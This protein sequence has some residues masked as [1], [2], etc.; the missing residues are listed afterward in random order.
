MLM[1][2]NVGT[3]VD[4]YDFGDN[5]NF[6][7]IQIDTWQSPREEACAEPIGYFTWFGGP[8]FLTT[9]YNTDWNEGPVPFPDA[10][11]ATDSYNQL[12]WYENNVWAAYSGNP[13]VGSRYGQNTVAA[14][15]RANGEVECSMLYN[16]PSASPELVQNDL[17]EPL[18]VVVNAAQAVIC[19]YPDST[20]LVT[21]TIPAEAFNFSKAS[22]E[23]T[24]NSSQPLWYAGTKSGS[25]SLTLENIGDVAQIA[26]IVP[27][28]CCLDS[29]VSTCDNSI[30][31]FE[32][33]SAAQQEVIL[34][35]GDI[36]EVD[37]YIQ[38]SLFGDGYCNVSIY[39]ASN[40]SLGSIANPSFN[41]TTGATPAQVLVEQMYF[42]APVGPPISFTV[43][44]DLFWP[45]VDRLT[46]MYATSAIPEDPAGYLSFANG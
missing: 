37:L 30:V 46:Y 19:E 44:F 13:L 45:M 27:E 22:L 26:T 38:T 4:P 33:F 15:I 31:D 16:V 40:T 25:L 3:L 17:S 43:S 10:S 41:T 6:F 8:E 12:A 23:L 5:L 28:L 42:S 14:N 36:Y 11:L 1:H 20:M 24:T 39:H 29:P 21:A 9:P 32:A 35:S 7:G 34:Q 18:T 2:C